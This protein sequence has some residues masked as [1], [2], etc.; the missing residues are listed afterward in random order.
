MNWNGESIVLMI[1]T[2]LLGIVLGGIRWYLLDI[3]RQLKELNRKIE[4]YEAWT[5]NEL[6]SVHSRIDN[7]LD[8]GDGR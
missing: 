6:K 5:A 8:K 1:V 4:E 7:H 3:H 2:G